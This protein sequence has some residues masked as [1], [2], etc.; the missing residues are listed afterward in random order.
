M[1]S[2]FTALV[3][4]Q[5]L[6]NI[7]ATPSTKAET[8]AADREVIKQQLLSL[9]REAI[10]HQDGDVHKFNRNFGKPSLVVLEQ[11]FE[12]YFGV[13]YLTKTTGA[14]ASTSASASGPAMVDDFDLSLPSLQA[15]ICSKFSARLAADTTLAAK[16]AADQRGN[17]VRSTTG[18]QAT[19]ESLLT[20]L[21]KTFSQLATHCAQIGVPATT[22]ADSETGLADVVLLLRKNWFLATLLEEQKGLS[23]GAQF[24]IPIESLLENH[25]TGGGCAPGFAGRFIRDLL[26]LLSIHFG[27][28]YA[29][30]K[31]KCRTGTNYIYALQIFILKVN[32]HY[33]FH[34]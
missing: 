28:D 15:I 32:Q 19:N 23:T 8:E 7:M 17:R 4:Y 31:E 33:K 26:Q 1:L 9:W 5:Q 18:G 30:Q 34:F 12:R 11:I 25:R 14:A 27:L 21:D 13:E 24:D 2:A 16:F 10:R 29:L 3:K 6:Q 20:E 22:Y